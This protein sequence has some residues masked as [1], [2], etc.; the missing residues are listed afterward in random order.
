MTDHE[1]FGSSQW[2]TPT[3]GTFGMISSMR[4]SLPSEHCKGFPELEK[5]WKRERLPGQRGPGRRR[6][7]QQLAPK[8]AAGVVKSGPGERRGSFFT[9]PLDLE[10]IS[11]QLTL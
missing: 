1:G 5:S 10:Q 11:R 9:A 7:M 4:L 6:V 2:A 8:G 3:I